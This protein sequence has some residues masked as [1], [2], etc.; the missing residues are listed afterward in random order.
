MGQGDASFG[1]AD[2]VE[3]LLGGDGNLQGSGISEADVFGS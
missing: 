3:G 1:H 2:E